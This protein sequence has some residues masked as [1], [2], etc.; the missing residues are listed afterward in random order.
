MEFDESSE[1]DLTVIKNSPM[2]GSPKSLLKTCLWRATSFS[3]HLG[4]VLQPFASKRE[5]QSSMVYV[6]WTLVSDG[7]QKAS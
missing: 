3:I 6:L 5:E 2:N 4:F 1:L 7:R